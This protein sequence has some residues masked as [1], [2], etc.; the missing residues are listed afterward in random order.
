MENPRP[1]KVAVVDE[2]RERLDASS[3]VLLTE[4]RGLKVGELAELRRALRSAGGDYKVYKNTLVR[5]AVQDRDLEGL[6]E[7]LVGPT[8]MAFVEGDIAAVAKALRDFSRTNPNL[9]LKGGVLGSKALS[10]DEARAL[11]ELP[12][13]EVLLARIAGGLAAPMQQLAG[14]L[15]ALPRNMAYGFKALIDQGGAP[16]APADAPAEEPAAEAPAAEADS[17]EAAPDAEAPAETEAAPAA[18]APAETEV[19]PA[20]E[21]DTTEAA[22]A[23]EAP[24]EEA[25]PAA[26]ADTPDP[27]TAEEA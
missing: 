23:A 17:T 15:Q 21:A 7:L 6:E 20:A 12:S 11:A 9:V 14:L 25:A 24:A 8:A 4:Y 26:E 27:E 16:G 13:R 3:A 18:E 5:L 19:A 2:V 22:P 1:E 10:A